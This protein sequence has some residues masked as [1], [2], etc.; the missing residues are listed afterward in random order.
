MKEAC[1]FNSENPMGHGIQQTSSS[2]F[3]SPLG[4]KPFL[5]T[6][7]LFQNSSPSMRGFG[8]MVIIFSLCKLPSL[9]DWVLVAHENKVRNSFFMNS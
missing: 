5:A 3:L 2:L 4:R 7:T 8:C 1:N 9:L 6:I